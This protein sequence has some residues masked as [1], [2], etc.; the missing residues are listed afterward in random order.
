MKKLFTLFL[1]VF[2]AGSYSSSG[3]TI[4]G[5]LSICVYGGTSTLTGTP[6]GGTWS[7][8]V[9]PV[10]AV[11]PTAGV[12]TAVAAGTTTI[13]YTTGSGSATA[14][15]TVTIAP[16][17]SLSSPSIF[18]GGTATLTGGPAGGIYSS[19]S[20]SVAW[21]GATGMITGISAGTATISYL[22]GGCIYN[23]IITVMPV[24][25]VSISGPSV[26]CAAATISL[27]G[28][29]PGGTWS[30]SNANA[31]TYGAGDVHGVSAGVDTV[32]YTLPS[33]CGSFTASHVVTV[34][35]TATIAPITG[36]FTIPC[37][38]T[39]TLADATPGGTWT[40][41]NFAIA[42][43]GS[44]SGI[45]AG[46]G[47]G[48][49]TISYLASIGCG[50]AVATTVVT[51]TPSTSAGTISGSSSVCTGGSVTLASTVSGGTWSV[52][53]VS[54]T[55][56]SAGV[57]SGVSPG[58][59]TIVYT[60]VGPCGMGTASYVVTVSTT[61]VV[62]PIT[63]TTSVACGSTTT[64]S[65]STAGGTWTSGS[66]LVATIGASS[67]IVSGVTSGTADIT[68]AVLSSCGM[69]TT[70]A[71]VT[72]SP[73]SVSASATPVSCSDN[74]TAVA[75]GGV[76]YA[77]MPTAGV[78]CP[79][80]GTTN[81]NPTATS[82]Y[83]VT[84]SAGTGCSANA[85]VTVNGDR[86][87]GNILFSP[88]AVSPATSKVWLVQFNPSDSSIVSLDSQ[89]T[90]FDGTD[91]YYQFDSKPTG[92]YLVKASILSS[93]AGASGYIPTYGASSAVWYAATPINHTG[94][95][96]V[97][98]IS[99]IWGTV[100][101][102]PGFISGYVYAGA[103][104][105]TSGEAPVEGMLIYLKD[106]VTGQVLTYTYT[107]A[108]GAYTF[109][110]LAYGSYIIYP[111]EYDYNTTPSSIITLSGANPSST[112]VTFKQHTDMGTITPW[113][114][115]NSVTTVIADQHISVVPNPAT[116]MITIKWSAIEKGD[117][118][119]LITDVMGREVYAAD[120]ENNLTQGEKKIGLSHLSQGMYMLRLQS[121]DVHYTQK[122]FMVK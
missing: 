30:L 32:T 78:S 105:G 16:S 119:L 8:S 2:L 69:A 77:W 81:I 33:G 85:T 14:V 10:A 62:G 57:V 72:V 67:G 5:T 45:V 21:V 13:T 52:T 11:H 60:V 118:Q 82:T 26:V 9:V 19:S 50:T 29:S 66:P 92:N 103:G 90:C 115:P 70:I 87:K 55:I 114:L 42:A 101:S 64:L 24:T 56:S 107:N 38:G 53:N 20:P 63:G 61:P 22:A 4:S 18:C 35:T 116:D 41:S 108:A 75:S 84:G 48:V 36:T 95:T 28:S 100:P 37:G 99:M 59:D 86:I 34:T 3:Q 111:E 120:I 97:Q 15:V 7:S 121:R 51:V 54:A 73:L 80:C 44:S 91:E 68:Y 98:N 122:F 89:L 110:S 74:Y 12:V 117:I 23:P 79:T 39:V 102:G 46:Y 47:V 6:A 40:S 113:T 27:S 109:N 94:A 49:T 43:P 96:D 106:G 17:A 31:S 71:V 1:L 83:T 65:N 93:I 88:T 104:K 25:S 76:T 112:G 58:V